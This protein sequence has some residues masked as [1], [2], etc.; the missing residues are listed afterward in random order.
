[1]YFDIERG[2]QLGRIEI[3]L[4]GGSVNKTVTNFKE[5][6][7]GWH[8]KGYKGSTFHRVIKG[9]MIQG[10]D[11]DDQHSTTGNLFV[12]AGGAIS[13]LSKKQAIVALSTSEPEYVALSLA[14]S[15]RAGNDLAQKIAV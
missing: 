6:A 2:D 13:W 7:K 5:L 8:G 14:K 15:S 11:S 4:F 1:M 3:G 9:F 12:M 10:G